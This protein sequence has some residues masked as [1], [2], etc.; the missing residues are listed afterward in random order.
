ME[1]VNHGLRR[2]G[3]A[4]SGLLCLPGGS[5]GPI[6][7]EKSR[8]IEGTIRGARPITA[9]H[10]HDCRASAFEDGTHN[11]PLAPQM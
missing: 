8:S 11:G 1:G 9:V 5:G 6:P 2:K 10:D 4:R 3:K 7:I